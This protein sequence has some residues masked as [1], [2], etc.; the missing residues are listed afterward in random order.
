MATGTG[1]TRLAIGL[2]YRLIK[3]DRFR[4]ILFVVDRNALGE[5]AGDKFKETRLEE[6]KTFNQIYDLKDVYESEIESTTKV[7]IA[8]VE[9]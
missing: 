2:I 4:R 1:K 3:S 7:R 8:T 6:L 5:Q 9:A